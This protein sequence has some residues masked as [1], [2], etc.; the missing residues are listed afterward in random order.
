[1][2]PLLLTL[3]SPA[4]A[5]ERTPAY[6]SVLFGIE[7]HW[8]KVHGWEEPQ[9]AAYGDDLSTF[10]LATPFAKAFLVLPPLYVEL[11]FGGLIG[12]LARPLIDP[13]LNGQ[14]AAEFYDIELFRF[15]MGPMLGDET[16]GV[17]AA[18]GY[19]AAGVGLTHSE[20]MSS[21]FGNVLSS[22]LGGKLVNYVV[23]DGVLGFHT[24]VGAEALIT[25]GGSFLDGFS[26]TVDEYILFG[27]WKNFGFY[28]H[29]GFRYRATSIA[30]DK[31][32]IQRVSTF[33][34]GL[35]VLTP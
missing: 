2:I 4:V 14:R 16:I 1:M 32:Q 24:H 5:M 9:I 8:N 3:C 23:L 27:P 13:K 34:L 10:H 22:G 31:D 20:V 19:S 12:F 29:P 6:G 15:Y 11:N 21:G 25:Q 28:L 7:P 33:M 18:F 30:Y 35:G 26:F 17:G